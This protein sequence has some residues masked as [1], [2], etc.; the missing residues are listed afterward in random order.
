M[1]LYQQLLGIYILLTHYYLVTNVNYK[2]TLM[3]RLLVLKKLCFFS[4][5]G[6]K[7]FTAI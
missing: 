4:E 6:H 7:T 2:L 1:F 5:L 3:F